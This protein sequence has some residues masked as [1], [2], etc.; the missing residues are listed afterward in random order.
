VGERGRLEHGLGVLSFEHGV[1]DDAAPDR[2]VD[3]VARLDERANGDAEIRVTV[4][5]D[6]PD[7]NPPG[8]MLSTAANGSTPSRSRPWIRLAVCQTFG[9]ARATRFS[10]TRTDPDFPQ[11]VPAQAV[12]RSP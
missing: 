4:R 2:E 6:A 3:V 1:V 9:P 11:A 8:N 5:I 7:D 12:P 10:T